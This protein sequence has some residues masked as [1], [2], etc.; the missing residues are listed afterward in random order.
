V[1]D[2]IGNHMGAIGEM[3]VE[4]SDIRKSGELLG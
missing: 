2:E 1:L 3:L 4:I